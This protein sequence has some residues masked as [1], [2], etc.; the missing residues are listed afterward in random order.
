M[1]ENTLKKDHCRRLD[2]WNLSGSLAIGRSNPVV[3]MRC[4]NR[5]RLVRPTFVPI[6]MFFT[7]RFVM[8]LAD[9]D[10]ALSQGITGAGDGRILADAESTEPGECE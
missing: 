6:G 7:P 2:L 5:G 9:R 4:A 10:F 3:R 1:C 8:K